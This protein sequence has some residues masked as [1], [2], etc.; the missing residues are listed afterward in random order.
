MSG[1]LSQQVFDRI[2]GLRLDWPSRTSVRNPEESLGDDDSPRK[3]TQSF[4]GLVL[5]KA[6]PPVDFGCAKTLRP[7]I[8]ANQYNRWR[9]GYL[10]ACLRETR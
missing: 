2:D 5:I 9:L 4:A 1:A 10:G 8:R 6:L 7:S 3:T